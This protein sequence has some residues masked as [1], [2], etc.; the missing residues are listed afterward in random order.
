MNTHDGCVRPSALATAW[1]QR[2]CSARVGPRF[3]GRARRARVPLVG[4]SSFLLGTGCLLLRVLLRLRSSLPRIPHHRVRKSRQGIPLFLQNVPKV[5]QQRE[6]ASRRDASV[7]PSRVEADPAVQFRTLNTGFRTAEPVARSGER[8]P[9]GSRSAGSRSRALGHS[10]LVWEKCLPTTVRD[11]RLMGNQSGIKG[12]RTQRPPWGLRK[13]ERW[14]IWK[15][16]P[17]G[18]RPQ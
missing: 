9:A 18:G 8:R 2:T 4:N 13:R 7:A 15:V 3:R 17:L 10:C 16:A 1:A 12:S 6:A 11:Y 14:G 5:P